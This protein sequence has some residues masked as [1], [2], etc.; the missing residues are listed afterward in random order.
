L[1]KR[2]YRTNINAQLL[3]KVGNN[4]LIK[5][6]LYY[7]RYNFDLHTNFTFFLV[8]SVNGDEIRQKEARNLYGYNGSYVHH[9]YIGNIKITTDAG[10][11]ARLDA[12]TNSE[13]SHTV[14]RYTLINQ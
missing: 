6:Q 13:L 5:N 4:D 11:N 12:T 7:S 2:I 1:H 8:D 14:N 3:T 10:I 9:G